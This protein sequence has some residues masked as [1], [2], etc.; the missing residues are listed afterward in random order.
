M[1]QSGIGRVK[2]RDSR[3]NV[4]VSLRGITLVAGD[5]LGDYI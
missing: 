5:I 3:T 4:D 2:V 1:R